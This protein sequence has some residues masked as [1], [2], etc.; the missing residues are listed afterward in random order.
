MK[1]KTLI[2][3]VSILLLCVIV[4]PLAKS[5]RDLN[6]SEESSET[7][8]SDNVI[9]DNGDKNIDI[10]FTYQHVWYEDNQKMIRIISEDKIT[11][12]KGDTY[13]Y[14]VHDY[15]DSGY[16]AQ[17]DE[18]ITGT[19]INDK[20]IVI[21]VYEVF[22][23]TALMLNTGVPVASITADKFLSI[24]KNNECLAILNDTGK[25][26]YSFAIDVL[27]YDYITRIGRYV[28]NNYTLHDGEC[29]I[30]FPKTG[31]IIGNK[32]NETERTM[33]RDSNLITFYDECNSNY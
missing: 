27:N 17:C 16:I 23:Y 12:K 15:F 25:D 2:L 6:T 7:N 29:L 19:A 26:V 22:N 30:L 3:L 33:M 1:K 5:F 24:G 20:R 10:Y 4:L 14:Q 11:C 9:K 32:T 18:I 21:D 13:E 31:E 28:V 8:V